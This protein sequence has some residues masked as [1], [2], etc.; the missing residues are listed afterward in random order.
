MA[1]SRAQNSSSRRGFY[2][3]QILKTGLYDQHITNSSQINN[4]LIVLDIDKH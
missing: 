4:P 1:E 3:F 2:K